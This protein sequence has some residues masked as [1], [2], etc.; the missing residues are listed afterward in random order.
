[1]TNK[2]QTTV[3]LADLKDKPLGAFKPGDTITVSYPIVADKPAKTVIYS[4]DVLY[5]ANTYPRGQD[6]EVRPD[7]IEIPVIHVRKRLIRGKEIIALA[8]QG[9]YEICLYVVNTSDFP[10]RNYGMEDKVPENFEYSGL[11][12]EPMEINK[13]EGTDVLKWKIEKIEAGDRFE[14]RYKLSGTGKPSDAQ[15]SR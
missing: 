9:E 15:E 2:L 8:A 4:S 13:E 7:V 5:T 11:S 12:L 6:L 10:L 14:I 1:M 3:K